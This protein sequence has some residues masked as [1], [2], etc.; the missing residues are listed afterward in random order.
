MTVVDR[1]IGWSDAAAR[2]L[3]RRMFDAAVAAADPM[4]VLAAHLPPAPK[5]RCVVVGAGK[6]AAA[7]AAA[8]DA[9]WPDVALSGAVVTPYGYD[10]PAGRIA[11]RQAAH[12]V[13]D[14]ASED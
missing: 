9:A 2:A 5:G 3:L 10:R 6:G 13:P 14:A 7:M 12:P 1:S 11:V 8:V 4:N